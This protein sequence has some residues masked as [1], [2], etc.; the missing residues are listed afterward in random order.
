MS[1]KTISKIIDAQTRADVVTA[2]LAALVREMHNA[3]ISEPVAM[4][5]LRDAPEKIEAA[6]T[7]GAGALVVYRM[8]ADSPR[9]IVSDQDSRLNA[10]TAEARAQNAPLFG[11]NPYRIA[12]L[13]KALQ[14][15]SAATPHAVP[16]HH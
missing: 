9:G 15:E 14:A 6:L 12:V 13:A 10:F 7:R 4:A 2:S 1:G 11:L 8:D 3:G 5:C 16:T